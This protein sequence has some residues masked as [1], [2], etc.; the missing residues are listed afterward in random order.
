MKKQALDRRQRRRKNELPAQPALFYFMRL[1]ERAEDRAMVRK[2]EQ[3]DSHHF[4]PF[5]MVEKF[6]RQVRQ[7]NIFVFVPGWSSKR[8]S[9]LITKVSF[10][11]GSVVRLYEG[12]SVRDEDN[13]YIRIYPD[14]KRGKIVVE[15]LRGPDYVPKM[16]YAH[17]EECHIIRFIAHWIV[18][19][20][21]WEKTRLRNLDLYKLFVRTRD[22]RLQRQLRELNEQ[23]QVRNIMGRGRA[24]NG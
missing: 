13:S 1:L 12:V 4:V 23:R 16:I 14:P 24:A 20:I 7:Q 3:E 22:E 6:M 18:D 8:E 19:R 2:F 21:D 17:R 9:L 15:R 5:E 10:S 11:M